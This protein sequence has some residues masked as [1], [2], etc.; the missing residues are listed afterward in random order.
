MSYEVDLLLLIIRF[1]SLFFFL[2]LLL[3]LL[4]LLLLRWSCVIHRLRLGTS[5]LNPETLLASSA[6][7]KEF[8]SLPVRVETCDARE[9]VWAR[10]QGTWWP[11]RR[12][13]PTGPAYVAALESRREMLVVFVGENDLY[14]VP[15][16]ETKAFVGDE[17][18]DGQLALQRA[19][20]IGKGLAAHYAAHQAAPPAP[21]AAAAAAASLPP[22]PPLPAAAASSSSSA[23]SSSATLSSASSMSL[24]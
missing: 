4:L 12:M 10:V 24:A 5:L 18:D 15:L 8:Y 20:A 2:R 22:Q 19:I 1:I 16:G 14:C 6:E 7:A 9:V 21:A 11:A 17:S 23:S 3:L 13:Q